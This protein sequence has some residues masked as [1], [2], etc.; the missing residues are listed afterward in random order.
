MAEKSKRHIVEP[1]WK[2]VKKAEWTSRRMK[3]EV[4]IPEFQ[5]EIDNKKLLVDAIIS[6]PKF[7]LGEVEM[8]VDVRPNK[9]SGFIGIF[10]HN[11]SDQA[12]MI[13]ATFKTNSGKVVS[14]E[15]KENPAQNISGWWFLSH[16]KYKEWAKKNGD[17]LKVEV[18]VIHYVKENS[19]DGWIRKKLK[20]E[21]DVQETFSSFGQAVMEDDSTTDFII[22]CDTKAFNVHKNFF[23]NRSPVFRA[24][25]LSDMEE[26]RKGEMFVPDMDEKTLGSVIKFI[27]TDQLEVVE[28]QDLQMIIHAADKY[29]LPGLFFLVVSQMKEVDVNGET[30]AVLLISGYKHEKEE[31]KELAYEKIRANRQIIEQEGFKK[32]MDGAPSTIWV[33]LVK[34][35]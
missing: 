5:K 10:L 33:D 24:A 12:Q 32:K 18:E 8:S 22:R 29:D 17:V 14:G 1:G 9:S 26:G 4:E 6:S 30:V 15:G 2:F 20:P 31:L 16:T 34:N 11:H 3:I 19:T 7:K 13:S 35:L 28:D 27:Y 21:Y 23:C 25:M